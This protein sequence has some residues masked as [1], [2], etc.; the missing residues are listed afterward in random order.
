MEGKLQIK[1]HKNM[2]LSI[3]V[4]SVMKK[5]SALIEKKG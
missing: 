1:L 3:L 2:Q 4:S 5:Q